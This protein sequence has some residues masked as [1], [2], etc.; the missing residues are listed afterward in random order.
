MTFKPDPL[1]E[2]LRSRLSWRDL[3]EEITLP[4]NLWHQM[5]ELWQRSIAHIAEGRVNEWGGV[6]VLG[7]QDDLTLVN[8]VEGTA[9]H[10]R[11]RRPRLGFF[12]GTFHTHPRTD[13]LTGIPFSATDIA[14]MINAG[15]RLSVVQ[16]GLEVFMMLPTEVSPL[17]V[18][19]AKLHLTYE[20]LQHEYLGEGHTEAD[21]AYYTNVDLCAM[22]NLLF[23][24]GSVFQPLEEV[25]RP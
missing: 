2:F 8:A 11:V 22:Y 15:E 23:Y 3:P 12:V 17:Q 16:S 1:I 6:L 13:G 19:V 5:D 20:S 7:E 24:L 18:D 21:A 9:F 10:L 25:Y 4:D 14:D